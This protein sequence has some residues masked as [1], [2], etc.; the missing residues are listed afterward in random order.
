[1]K[2]KIEKKK[3]ESTQVNL[4]NLDHEI[5]ITTKKQIKINYVVQFTINPMLKHKIKK[6]QKKKPPM[7]TKKTRDLGHEIRITLYNAN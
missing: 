3:V 4:L 6:R 7:S 1:L 5:R 2:D